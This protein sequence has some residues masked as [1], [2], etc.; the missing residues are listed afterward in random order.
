I[1]SLYFRTQHGSNTLVEEKHLLQEI[2]RL[3]GTREK[4]LENEANAIHKCICCAIKLD[5]NSH[6]VR[7]EMQL[8]S[9]RIKNLKEQVKFMDNEIISLEEDVT[10]ANKRRH[11]AYEL[12]LHLIKQCDT[13]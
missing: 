13:Q 1:R 4:V 6:G 12:S 5:H 7:E 3:E 9:W 10:T 11:A 2:K 8:I